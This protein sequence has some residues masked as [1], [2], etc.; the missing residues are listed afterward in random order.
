LYSLPMLKPEALPNES[1][2]RLMVLLYNPLIASE[3]KSNALL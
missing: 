3:V 2:A 1:Y